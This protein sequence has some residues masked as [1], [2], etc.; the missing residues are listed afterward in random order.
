MHLREKTQ[1]TVQSHSI[2]NGGNSNRL[3]VRRRNVNWEE[4]ELD[5]EEKGTP[6]ESVRNSKT[7]AKKLKVCHVFKA[8][9]NRVGV[10]A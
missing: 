3:R 8:F 9:R 6:M 7:I 2:G 5:S 1:E 4:Q 10:R